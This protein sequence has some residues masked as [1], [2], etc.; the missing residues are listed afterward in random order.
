[1]PVSGAPTTATNSAPDT[2]RRKRGLRRRQ[3]RGQCFDADA[4]QAIPRAAPIASNGANKPLE[5][6]GLGK[7]SENDAHDKQDS[8]AA[9]RGRR[10]ALTGL[11]R[12]PASYRMRREKRHQPDHCANHRRCVS[13][14]IRRI[15]LSDIEPGD[16]D[17]T[18][19][20]PNAPMTM[21]P[22]KKVKSPGADRLRSTAARVRTIASQHAHDH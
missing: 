16:D 10:R 22:T 11:G 21:P 3:R 17:V 9:N 7:W 6:P 20:T 4:E 1:M 8:Q 13:G 15:S 18:V 19:I 14:E 12:L 5:A 2:N